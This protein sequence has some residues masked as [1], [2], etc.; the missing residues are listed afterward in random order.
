MQILKGNI[1][2]RSIK[3]NLTG[4]ATIKVIA[5]NNSST[6]RPLGLLDAQG[7]TLQSINS[8]KGNAGVVTYTVSSAG[9]YYICSLNSGINLY[10]IIIEY[11]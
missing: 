8:P 1:N 11:N 2:E 7:N 3:V 5:K 9:T 6:D 10:G 4:A